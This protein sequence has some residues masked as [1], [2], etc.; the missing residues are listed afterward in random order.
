MAKEPVLAPKVTTWINVEILD[1]P[2]F[3]SN[4]V[5]AVEEPVVEV[6]DVEEPV[7]EVADVE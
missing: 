3:P 5:A 7:V 4:D 1:E 2:V 6:V